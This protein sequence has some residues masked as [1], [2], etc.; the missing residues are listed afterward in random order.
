MKNKLFCLLLIVF[1]S[2]AQEIKKDTLS[3]NHKLNYKALIIPSLLIGYGFIGI[4][5]DQ[6]KG[7]N[8]EIK[9]EL[10]ENIDEINNAFI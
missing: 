6:I 3:V 4:E 10:N 8:A 2:K 9:N 5:S 1:S 7:F